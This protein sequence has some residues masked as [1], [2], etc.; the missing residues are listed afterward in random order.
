MFAQS[1]PSV[2]TACALSGHNEICIQLNN[3]KELQW[4]ITT[5]DIISKSREKC[6]QHNATTK[7]S[8]R[9]TAHLANVGLKNA[10]TTGLLKKKIQKSTL[11]FKNVKHECNSEQRE[12]ARKKQPSLK[13]FLF[14]LS[15]MNA[16]TGE[17]EDRKKVLKREGEIGKK[18]KNT[19]A[20]FQ[21]GF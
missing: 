8:F 21:L 4:G 20:L 7:I 3:A 2:R 16:K 17:C 18:E 1:T 5:R 19:I 6:H 13:L 9:A 15:T 11:R 14:L 12:R 10:G